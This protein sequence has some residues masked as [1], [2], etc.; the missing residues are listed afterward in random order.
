MISQEPDLDFLPKEHGFKITKWNTLDVDPDRLETSVLGVFAGGDAVTGPATVI[1]AIAAGQRAA[2]AVHN[3]LSKDGDR[4]DYRVPRS[5]KKVPRINLTEEEK[6]TL[7]RPDMPH[8]PVAERKGS[9]S[10]VARGFNIEAAVNE[11]KRCLRCDQ[12]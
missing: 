7:R 10:E 11:A 5:Y 6:S 3:Y 4:R 2:V 12:E 8:I 9:F 1:E